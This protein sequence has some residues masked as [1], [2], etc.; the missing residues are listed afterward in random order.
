[1][2]K[3]GNWGDWAVIGGRHS[4]EP[5]VEK[6]AADHYEKSDVQRRKEIAALP[7]KKKHALPWEKNLYDPREGDHKPPRAKKKSNKM[8]K[9]QMIIF[10]DGEKPDCK[11]YSIK[12][13]EG[14]QPYCLQGFASCEGCNRYQAQNKK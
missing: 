1:M 11:Y 10:R 6:S 13:G 8:P 2:P 7:E 9:K 4:L 5:G 3:H 14:C 12:Q